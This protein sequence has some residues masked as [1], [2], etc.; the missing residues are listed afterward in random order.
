M[1]IQN[2][3]A[4]GGQKMPFYLEQKFNEKWTCLAI[5]VVTMFRMFNV[6]NIN[7]NKLDIMMIMNANYT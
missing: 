6:I 7:K 4:Q 3:G 1:K 5:I 2:V